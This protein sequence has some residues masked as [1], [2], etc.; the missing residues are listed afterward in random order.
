MNGKSVVG[1]IESSLD[2]RSLNP[3]A[4]V[5]V[6]YQWWISPKSWLLLLH[7]VEV[8]A[9]TDLYCIVDFFVKLPCPEYRQPRVDVK[10]AMDDGKTLT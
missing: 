6:P 10:T 9:K 1:V 5:I 8:K 7:F 3:P 2:T 4:V